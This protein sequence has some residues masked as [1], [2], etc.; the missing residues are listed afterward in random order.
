MWN[1]SLREKFNFYFQGVLTRSAT[2]ETTRIYQFIA[3]NQAFFHLWW[4]ENLVKI[5][6]SYNIMTM[7]AIQLRIIQ[8]VVLKSDCKKSRWS[9]KR[10]GT[11]PPRHSLNPPLCDTEITS[12]CTTSVCWGIS[13]NTLGDATMNYCVLK[14]PYMFRKFC[15]VF[16]MLVVKC[17]CSET[18]NLH[19][20]RNMYENRRLLIQLL[21]KKCF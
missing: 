6:N 8:F 9:Q 3:N 16:I 1:S 14:V 15:I 21:Y 17:F 4:K 2:R 5:K 11:R 7:V 18:W 10:G 13:S 12:Y 20:Y 19:Y